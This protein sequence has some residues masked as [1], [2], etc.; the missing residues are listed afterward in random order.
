ML[1]KR[2]K[3]ADLAKMLG[4]SSAEAQMYVNGSSGVSVESYEKV[5]KMLEVYPTVSLISNDDIS[6]D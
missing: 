1:E 2:F 6:C 4:V 3:Q 5:L